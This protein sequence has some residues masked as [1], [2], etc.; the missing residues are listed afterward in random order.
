MIK[1]LN[2]AQEL[3]LLQHMDTLSR[4]SPITPAQ[5]QQLINN[6]LNLNPYLGQK[7]KVDLIDTSASV[8]TKSEMARYLVT[9]FQLEKSIIPHI[10]ND[11]SNH[12]YHSAIA[13]LAQL[14]VVA[15]KNGNF[16][17]DNYVLR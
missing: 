10:F 15:G 11:I 9:V 14:G 6:T 5:A 4:D 13:K 1:K 12:S 8:L 2:T 3:G 17:P 7:E 16:Y